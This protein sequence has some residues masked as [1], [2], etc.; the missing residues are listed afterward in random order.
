M[1]PA[2]WPVALSK[3][4]ADRGVG[5]GYELDMG[6]LKESPAFAGVADEAKK[7]QVLARTGSRHLDRL[8]PTSSSS[9]S[10]A[11]SS[12]VS[13]RARM[14]CRRERLPRAM[15]SFEVADRQQTG[16]GFSMT[17]PLVPE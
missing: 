5:G 13:M 17:A 7:N 14:C 16:A 1:F 4:R 9:A 10:Q 6:R 15:G 11:T 3:G 2:L 8:F 12:P